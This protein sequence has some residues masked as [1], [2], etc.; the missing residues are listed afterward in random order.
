MWNKLWITHFPTII[1]NRSTSVSCAKRGQYCKICSWLFERRLL[2]LNLLRT[3]RISV[4]TKES[5][6]TEEPSTYFTRK[7]LKVEKHSFCFHNRLKTLFPMGPK[8]KTAY[9]CELRKT[10]LKTLFSTIVRLRKC[11]L[12]NSSLSEKGYNR[13]FFSGNG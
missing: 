1:F 2:I 3:Q 11:C 6:W 5:S 10:P 8:P 13:M 4:S 7:V 12:P 9:S